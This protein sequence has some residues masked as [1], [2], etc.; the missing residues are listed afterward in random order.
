[1]G[2]KFSNFDTQDSFDNWSC[3]GTNTHRRD[4]VSR[5]CWNAH[6]KLSTFIA[7]YLRY[8]CILLWIEIKWLIMNKYVQKYLLTIVNT[9]R[10]VNIID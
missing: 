5:C 4:S 8:L 2:D 6:I 3:K 7:E 9:N 1:M 10:M